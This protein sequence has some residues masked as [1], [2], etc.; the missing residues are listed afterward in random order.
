MDA[1][2]RLTVTRGRGRPGDYVKASGPP[3]VVGTAAPFTGL[4]PALYERGVSVTVSRRVAVPAAALDPS[5]KSISRLASVLARRDA[6]AA[7]AHEAIL[8]DA[9]GRLTEGTASN[10]FVVK[11]GQLSTPPVPEGGLPGITRQ[12][13]LELARQADIPSREEAL[14]ATR[15]QRVDEVFLTNTSWELLPVVSIDGRAVG[16]GQPGPVTGRLLSRYREL[17]RKECINA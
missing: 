9:Q 8:L 12:T 17:I 16:G 10:L 7:G 6:V 1:R 13:V 11:E 3:T 4:A 14:P 5:I 15:L 2:L